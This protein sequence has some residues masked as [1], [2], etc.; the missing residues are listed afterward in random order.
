MRLLC[1]NEGEAEGVNAARRV[2]RATALTLDERISATADPAAAAASAMTLLVVP[3]QSV[4]ENARRLADALPAG[5]ML[6]H[7]TKG[8]ER[9]SAK[10]VSEVLLEE[11]PQLRSAD[12]CV[13]SGPNLAGEI[14]RGLPAATVIAGP[15]ETKVAAAQAL[16]HAQAFRAYASSDRTG[17][18][19]AG[20]LKNVIALAAGIADGLQLGD[21]AKAGIITRG[22]AEMIRLGVAAGAEPITFAGLA[23]V[24]DLIA[25]CY[26]DLSRNHRTGRAIGSGEPVASAVASAGGVVEGVEAT[27][28]SCLLAERLG[29]DMPIARGLRS[30]LLEGAH[31]LEAIRALLEREPARETRGA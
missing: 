27:A 6:L 9:G 4:R 19:L 24:G 5:A 25:T 3:S 8:L 31:P 14:Q 17:V 16:V 11:L 29:V 22:L 13:L 12:V 20:S 1:R 2:A 26:S 23:G 18:E 7:A 15:D 30:V 21:N 10:R 28:A